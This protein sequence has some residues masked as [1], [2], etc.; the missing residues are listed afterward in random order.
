MALPAWLASIVHVPLALKVTLEPEMEHTELL[1]ESIAKVT[2]LPD[3]PPVA[4]TL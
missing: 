1:A 2:G 3:P 4:V